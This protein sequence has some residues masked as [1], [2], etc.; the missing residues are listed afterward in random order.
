MRLFLASVGKFS[1]SLGLNPGLSFRP[2]GLEFIFHVLAFFPYRV[3]SLSLG[4]RG[5][6]ADFR[7]IF[8]ELFGI[9][10]MAVL[11]T[12]SGEILF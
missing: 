8:K 3:Q 2:L 7:G 10:R 6:H 9:T 11:L 5:K 12:T 4:V 1:R